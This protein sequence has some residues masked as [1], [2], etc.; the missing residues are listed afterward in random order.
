LPRQ[1]TQR[2]STC[3]T[4]DTKKSQAPVAIQKQSKD[5]D[6]F[7]V[8]MDIMHDE[9]D[10]FDKQENTGRVVLDRDLA[11]IDLRWRQTLATLNHPLLNSN[12]P[13]AARPFTALLVTSLSFRR[14]VS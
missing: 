13:L 11:M 12:S 6:N 5:A 8:Y 10:A 2:Q 1:G 4:K 3:Y 7:R 14:L 9:Y